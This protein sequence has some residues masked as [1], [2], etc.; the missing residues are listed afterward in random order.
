[1]CH[2]LLM[3]QAADNKHVMDGPFAA[4]FKR[5]IGKTYYLGQIVP[6]GDTWK[7]KGI[8]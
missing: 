3:D 1:M 4:A 7:A 5:T 8:D 2:T 6:S